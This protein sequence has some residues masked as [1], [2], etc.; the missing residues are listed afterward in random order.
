MIVKHSC[1]SV[2]LVLLASGI[3][4]A[5]DETTP[6]AEPNQEV[7]ATVLAAGDL[8]PAFESIDEQGHPWKSTDH[9]GKRILV[10]YFYPG[11]F[12][13]GCIKQAEAYR[14]GLAKIKTANSTRCGT[15]SIR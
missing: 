5:T 15:S 7:A 6:A 4:Q 10:L 11:D 13:G 12:T 2:I 1:L 14:D 9:V 3:L 8:L